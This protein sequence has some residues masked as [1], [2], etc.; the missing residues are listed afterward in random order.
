MF[1]WVRN[2][3]EAFY[4]L[5]EREVIANETIASSW[6]EH[7]KHI[8]DERVL[9]HRYVEPF[10]FEWGTENAKECA[11]IIAD[12]MTASLISKMKEIQDLAERIEKLGTTPR[13]EGEQE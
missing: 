12:S 3:V 6:V 2:T 13:N 5:K 10:D 1:G 8:G 4:K 9:V 11:D 7:N